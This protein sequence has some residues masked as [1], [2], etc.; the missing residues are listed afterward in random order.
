MR[1]NLRQVRFKS[2]SSVDVRFCMSLMV[3]FNSVLFVIVRTF[4]R[5]KYVIYVRF[6]VTVTSRWWEVKLIRLAFG[7]S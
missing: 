7:E 3:R 4:L 5:S 2:F 6:L 1:D